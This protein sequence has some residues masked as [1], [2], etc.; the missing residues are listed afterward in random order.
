MGPL[1]ENWK[2]GDCGMC[3]CL[4]CNN[5]CNDDLKTI[6]CYDVCVVQNIDCASCPYENTTYCGFAAKSMMQ[7]MKKLYNDK[8]Q[9]WKERLIEGMTVLADYLKMNHSIDEYD[10]DSNCISYVTITFDELDDLLKDLEQKRA[11]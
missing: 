11:R 10:L 7:F 3:D 2:V 5:N 1:C 8:I 6:D 4:E 9:I